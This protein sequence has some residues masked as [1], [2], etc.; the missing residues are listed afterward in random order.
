MRVASIFLTSGTVSIV[1]LGNSSYHE[2][3]INGIT[4]KGAGQRN[5]VV[6][7]RLLR[8]VRVGR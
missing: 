7:D 1:A 2:N 6:R 8:R 3:G 4:S 5:G